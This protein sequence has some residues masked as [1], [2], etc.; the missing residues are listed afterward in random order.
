[1]HRKQP[2]VAIS[3]GTGAGA[4]SEFNYEN[5]G[6]TLNALGLPARRV[7][8]TSWYHVIIAIVTAVGLGLTGIWWILRYL[9]GEQKIRFVVADLENGGRVISG[10]RHGEGHKVP[11]CGI[12][13]VLN[14]LMM[15][16]LGVTHIQTTSACGAIEGGRAEVGTLALIEQTLDAAHRNSTFFW[17]GPATHTSLA[18]PPPTCFC[19]NQLLA[20]AAE[21][22]DIELG[23]GVNYV[24]I[25]GP[26]FGNA[27]TSK[28]W[29]RN[30]CDVVG[31]CAHDESRTS[32]EGQIHYSCLALLSDPDAKEGDEASQEGI[33]NQLPEL[34]RQAVA[35]FKQSLVMIYAEDCQPWT[36]KCED[37]LHK[38]TITPPEQ[39]S[40][41][42]RRLLRFLLRQ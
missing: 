32:H 17:R 26:P 40:R 4:G 36:C 11:P 14:A 13:W 41:Y 27:L 34:M 35:V 7:W 8:R 16:W 24:T 25:D 2:V 42:Q 31:Q 12:D 30:E 33:D 23:S 37:T 1:M 5:I 15:V 10:S 18:D 29:H 20:R 22:A 39:L 38:A 6:T 19:Q 3:M 9:F 28:E 21:E